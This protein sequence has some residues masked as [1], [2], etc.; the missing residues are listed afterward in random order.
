MLHEHYL[1]Y[2]LFFYFVKNN[3]HAFQS[4][5]FEEYFWGFFQNLCINLI[6]FYDICI[7]NIQNLRNFLKIILDRYKSFLASKEFLSKRIRCISML[8]FLNE[9]RR[10]ASKKL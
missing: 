6:V 3:F 10:R 5:I 1:T 7:T 4:L 9:K 2:E 8:V